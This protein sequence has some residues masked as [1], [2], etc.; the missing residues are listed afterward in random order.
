M[1]DKGHKQSS[2][3]SC[4]SSYFFFVFVF[5][6]DGLREGGGLGGD[7]SLSAYFNAIWCPFP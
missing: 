4:N 1:F 7:E 2:T 3:L 6:G 5:L